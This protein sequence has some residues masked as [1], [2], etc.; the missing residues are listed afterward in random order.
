MARK[1]RRSNNKGGLTAQELADPFLT[2]GTAMGSGVL[3][4]L[5]GVAV[6]LE[7]WRRGHEDPV[8]E[9]LD[10]TQQFTDEHTFIPR[11]LKGATNL[12]EAMEAMA[13]IGA[14]M[15]Q[16]LEWVGDKSIEAG[17]PPWV[18]AAIQ[19]SPD[20]LGT[21][22]GGPALL[23]QGRNVS[24]VL[25]RIP[26]MPGRPGPGRYQSGMVGGR[27][28]QGLD[29]ETL[30]IA[31]DMKGRFT[32]D[33]IWDRTALETGQPSWYD[34]DKNFKYEFSDRG[35]GGLL[36]G[37]STKYEALAQLD[38]SDPHL[39]RWHELEKERA[40]QQQAGNGVSARGMMEKREL[41]NRMGIRDRYDTVEA[42]VSHPVALE[43]YPDLQDVGF[44]VED[45]GPGTRGQ[46]EY[47]GGQ[48]NR[49]AIQQGL[50]PGESRS[51]TLHEMN[52]GIQDIEGHPRGGNVPEF[53]RTKNEATQ[54]IGRLDQY[55]KELEDVK[56]V[57]RGG[58]F[59][60]VGSDPVK[61]KAKL[62]KIVAEQVDTM[63]IRNR[64]VE[65]ANI[66]PLAEYKRQLGEAESRAVQYRRDLNMGERL[67]RPFWID[68]DKEG[69]IP[70]QN[71]RYR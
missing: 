30:D 38:P 33:Q 10:F 58:E 21:L 51:I 49:I 32:N 60:G 57:I 67:D 61:I 64:H 6:G 34:Q 16:G 44:R 3:G 62:D 54:R 65:R 59:S 69:A 48:G 56:E 31:E 63:R 12:E 29:P 11:T 4:G 53:R 45:L 22:W 35:H 71:L 1:G 17:A 9:Y 24:R 55:L 28:S 7:S 39:M 8:Q 13:A 2:A 68:F 66:D 19:S 27:R 43:N 40:I 47:G 18:S 37:P 42:Q 41:E 36:A 23:R 70:I 20:I 50:S 26:Q 5:G 14:P 25:D 46:Y 52:H 15:E